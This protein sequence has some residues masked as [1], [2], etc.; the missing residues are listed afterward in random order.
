MEYGEKLMALRNGRGMTQ[1][2]LA[3]VSGVSQSTV[4]RSERGDS[5]SINALNAM[6]AVFGMRLKPMPIEADPNQLS[7]FSA[8]AK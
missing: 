8:E 4:S 6:F 5:M 1:A 3:E 7:M 2:T